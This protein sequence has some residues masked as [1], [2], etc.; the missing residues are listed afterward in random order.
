M[1]IINSNTEGNMDHQTQDLLNDGRC[2]RCGGKRIVRDLDSFY[3]LELSER[4]I[5]KYCLYHLDM[6]EVILYKKYLR[7]HKIKPEIPKNIKINKRTGR[8]RAFNPTKEQEI[9]NRI[10]VMKEEYTSLTDIC[11][12]IGEDLGCSRFTI[13]NLFLRMRD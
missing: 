6:R 8:P 12:I 13:R 7:K 2:P 5:T 9:Y 11:E 10:L 1:E 3:C 4:A